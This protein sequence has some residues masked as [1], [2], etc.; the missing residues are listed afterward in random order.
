MTTPPI[1]QGISRYRDKQ[2]L[3]VGGPHSVQHSRILGW[4]P[5]PIMVPF[6]DG[7][8]LDEDN[9]FPQYIDPDTPNSLSAHIVTDENFDPSSRKSSV[10]ALE[11]AVKS[12]GTFVVNIDPDGGGSVELADTMAD[13]ELDF[14]TILLVRAITVPMLG[15]VTDPFHISKLDWSLQPTVG[16]GSD[17]IQLSDS[18]F[19]IGLFPNNVDDADGTSNFEGGLMTFFAPAWIDLV[20]Y[21]LLFT[22]L[23]VSVEDPAVG[24]DEAIADWPIGNPAAQTERMER[25]FSI[26]DGFIPEIPS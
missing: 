7:V 20:I 8:L 18:R 1:N 4:Q 17:S 23:A 26:P 14:S 12:T 11:K 6:I 21:G 9:D 24:V 10:I 19:S 2:R 13:I 22:A 5:C 25:G 16:A 15:P 3:T